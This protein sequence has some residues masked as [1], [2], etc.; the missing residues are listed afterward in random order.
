MQDIEFKYNYAVDIPEQ[1]ADAVERAFK[2]NGFEFIPSVDDNSPEG[3]T[4]FNTLI[5]IAVSEEYIVAINNLKRVLDGLI[6]TASELSDSPISPLE[7]D[8]IDE[9]T[10]SPLRSNMRIL[11]I[12]LIDSIIRTALPDGVEFNS[13]EINNT[14]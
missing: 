5:C 10:L 13:K 3:M 14:E 7:N 2:I 1:H 4:R 11:V 12:R 6:E 9:I 8:V